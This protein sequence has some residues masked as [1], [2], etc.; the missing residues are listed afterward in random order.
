LCGGCEVSSESSSA[1]A[2]AAIETIACSN[3]ASLR[4]D[5]LVVPLS[6]RTNYKA[7][8]RISWSVAGGS[9]L[10]SGFMFLHID[11]S[12]SSSFNS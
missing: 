5:G 2:H 7:A 12:Q 9:K 4:F 8:S 10:N 6:F 11:C 3:A 1:R